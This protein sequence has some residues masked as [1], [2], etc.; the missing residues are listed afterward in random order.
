MPALLAFYLYRRSRDMAAGGVSVRFD[1]PFSLKSAINFALVFATI[2]MVTRLATSYLG[3]EWLPLVAIVSGLPDADAIA[4]TLSSLEHAG[5]IPLDWASFNLV[6]GALS[7]T[8]M[9]LILIFSLGHRTLFK[10]LLLP[11]LVVGAV[12]LVTMFLYYDLGTIA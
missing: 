4:F 8:F 1:N 10:Q 2:L 3:N 7:N 5:L 6:L 12:G 11:F 9:K